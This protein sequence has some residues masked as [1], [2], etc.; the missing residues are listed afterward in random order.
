MKHIPNST[1][2]N[3]IEFL[4]I[5][6]YNQCKS[7][8]K[9]GVLPR[10]KHYQSLKDVVFFFKFFDQI[11]RSLINLTIQISVSIFHYVYITDTQILAAYFFFRKNISYFI[12]NS[13][14]DTSVVA[15]IFHNLFTLPSVESVIHLHVKVQ[16]SCKCT[17]SRRTAY[18]QFSFGLK[19]RAKASTTL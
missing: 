14:N 16:R 6:F 10:Q 15:F 2:I 19:L 3:M 13:A 9:C 7:I 1:S 4:F 8:T 11:K 12:Y 5:T 18:M 17:L